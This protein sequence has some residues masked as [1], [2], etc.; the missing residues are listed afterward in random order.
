MI[1]D[2]ETD[3]FKGYAYVEFSDSQS[4]TEALSFNKAV[5]LLSWVFN[6]INI[7]ELGKIF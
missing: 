2:R 4:L 1:R 5:I 3:E 6:V 7:R